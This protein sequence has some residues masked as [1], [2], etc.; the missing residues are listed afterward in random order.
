[1]CLS[2]W[3]P[4]REGCSHAST[5][6]QVSPPPAAAAA[7][8]AARFPYSASYGRTMIKFILGRDDGG[9]AL[10]G[11]RF[12][13]GGWVRSGREQGGGT[14]AFVQL[15]DGSL[16]QDLQARSASVQPCVIEER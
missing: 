11:S 4:G 16:A 5:L 15:N 6:A 12:T 10:A 2:V 9:V 13:V 3:A 14:F 1:M 7:Q 8:P